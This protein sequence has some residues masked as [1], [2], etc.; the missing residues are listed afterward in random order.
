MD[1]SYLVLT[2]EE[3]RNP[4]AQEQ[5][6]NRTKDMESVSVGGKRVLV[7]FLLLLACTVLLIVVIRFIL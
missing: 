4:M 5:G 3:A 6:D 7:G 1:G 2:H